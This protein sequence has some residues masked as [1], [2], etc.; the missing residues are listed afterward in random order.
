[1]GL[2]LL[3]SGTVAR[4]EWV[5]CYTTTSATSD[6]VVRMLSV[7]PDRPV[8]S[9][10]F[11]SGFDDVFNTLE[12]IYVK[13]LSFGDRNTYAYVPDPPSDIWVY[14]EVKSPLANPSPWEVWGY[15]GG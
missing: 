2:Q 11:V 8:P 4:G 7:T 15:I 12:R 10:V 14:H 13:Q 6:F 5:K 9:F 1:M 3:A